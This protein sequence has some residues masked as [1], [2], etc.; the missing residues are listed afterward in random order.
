MDEPT[1]IYD[2]K[3]GRTGQTFFGC[4]SGGKEVRLYK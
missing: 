1:M 4:G 3:F 2:T